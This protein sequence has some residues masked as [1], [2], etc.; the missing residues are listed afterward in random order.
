MLELH[1]TKKESGQKI[2]L[3]ELY[4]TLTQ[5]WSMSYI[6]WK[7]NFT[8]IK[9]IGSYDLEIHAWLNTFIKQWQSRKPNIAKS[10]Q[11]TANQWEYAFNEETCLSKESELS[12]FLSLLTPHSRR[13]RGSFARSSSPAP[14]YLGENI[15]SISVIGNHCCLQKNTPFFGLSPQYKR[16]KKY[17]LSPRKWEHA[18][19]P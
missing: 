17:T 4:H 3:L 13:I 19:D 7:R 5:K 9:I 6:I 8:S 18:C 2:I 14:P 1:S 10:H 16:P 12:Q 15:P 11:N